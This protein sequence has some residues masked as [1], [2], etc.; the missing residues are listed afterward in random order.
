M[1]DFAHTHTGKKRCQEKLIFT[2]LKKRLEHIELSANLLDYSLRS[3]KSN[4][5]N[6]KLIAE[7]KG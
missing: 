6:I 5:N 1:R 3:N 2:N 7:I 4:I